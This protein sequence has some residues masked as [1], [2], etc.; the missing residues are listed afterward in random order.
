MMNEK[1]MKNNSNVVNED[2]VVKAK[3]LRSID[4]QLQTDK[5][6]WINRK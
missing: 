1:Q 6:N 5:Y 2:C 4:Q 3:Y